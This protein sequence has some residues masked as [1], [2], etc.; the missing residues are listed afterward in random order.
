MKTFKTFLFTF[1]IILAFHQCS[2]SSI[3]K[4]GKKNYSF[5]F[6]LLMGD[7]PDGVPITITGKVVDTKTEKPIMGADIELDGQSTLTD[8]DGMFT[9]DYV[10]YHG[11]KVM[12]VTNQGYTNHQRI[13]KN[14]STDINDAEITIKPY[15]VTR[16]VDPSVGA[17]VQSPTGITVKIP[18]ISGV[19]EKLDVS[20][21]Y[22]DASTNDINAV[23]G[24]FMGVQDGSDQQK[25]LMSYGVI[26]VEARGSTTGQLYELTNQNA[27]KSRLRNAKSAVA[28]GE[29]EIVAPISGN[30]N[31]DAP[32]T[33]PLWYLDETKGVWVEEGTATKEGLFYRGKVNHFSSWNLDRLAPGE[34]CVIVKGGAGTPVSGRGITNGSKTDGTIGY[35]GQTVLT[36]PE[37]STVVIGGRSVKVGRCS[38]LTL[39]DEGC[40]DGSNCY[41]K[42]KGENCHKPKDPKQ[43]DPCNDTHNA[44]DG[45]TDLLKAGKDSNELNTMRDL[46][47]KAKDKSNAES[48]SSNANQFLTLTPERKLK[49]FD[50]QDIQSVSDQQRSLRTDFVDAFEGFMAPVSDTIHNLQ[51]NISSA[52]N[53]N[54]TELKD[55]QTAIDNEKQKLQNL[56]T[57]PESGDVIYG[58]TDFGHNTLMV[59]DQNNNRALIGRQGI[60]YLSGDGKYVHIALQD[61]GFPLSMDTGDGKI[62]YYD[63]S[64]N[65][66]LK[67]EYWFF[68]YNGQQIVYDMKVVDTASKTEQ[69]FENQVVPTYAATVIAD[70]NRYYK[71]PVA[72][73]ESVTPARN[74]F[75][76]A[77]NSTITVSFTQ[78]MATAYT[79]NAFSLKKGVETVAGTIS[80]TDNKTMVFTPSANLAYSTLYSIQ[81]LN[82]K[83]SYGHLVSLAKNR[84]EPWESSFGTE[85]ETTVVT[86]A[87]SLPDTGQTKCYN[88]TAEIP[89]GSDPNF[90]RQDAEFVGQRSYTGPTQHPIYTNDYTTKDNVTGLTWKTCSEGLSGVDCSV[91]SATAYNY[92]NSRYLCTLFSNSANNGAG[93]AGKTD[94]R[95]P[96]IEELRMLP[97]YGRYK[98]FLPKHFI[99]NEPRPMNLAVIQM[100]P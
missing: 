5:L 28:S 63:F 60:Q 58:Y 51:Q 72:E 86:S 22:F 18:P 36:F 53:T 85:S 66:L 42:C 100:D 76:V 97:D 73:F 30:L 80:W 15:D 94:W 62:V 96:T 2:I 8:V 52:D 32:D 13:L 99:Q 44:V 98:C 89:C 91:G 37:G 57:L 24:N 88:D 71:T 46:L 33:I 55:L 21:T 64:K 16:T 50:S 25:Q 39:G 48:G 14:V 11:E 43:A 19:D 67:N 26:S 38:S 29:F 47:A 23:S 92:T 56:Q 40:K 35:D 75:N 41:K 3:V 93:Y 65:E 84:Y 6:F 49:K 95:L 31:N 74:Q 45:I 34:G 69:V 9:L 68:S 20:L 79:Q 7:Y 59:A 82:V 81:F 61:Y 78:D 10:T 54:Q 77:I 90:P 17:T 12:Q 1:I 87:T 27:S 83:D 70:T 4:G